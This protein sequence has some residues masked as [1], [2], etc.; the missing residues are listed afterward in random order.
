MMAP[1]ERAVA[2]L[3]ALLCPMPFPAW[4]DVPSWL[5]A[6]S[7]LLAFRV[8][9][10]DRTNLA[11]QQVDSIGW[12]PLLTVDESDPDVLK[13]TWC[14][15]NA[16]ELPIDIDYFEFTPKSYWHIPGKHVEAEWGGKRYT[17]SPYDIRAGLDVEYQFFFSDIHIPPKEVWKSSNIRVGVKPQR[18]KDADRVMLEKTNCVVKICCITDN[19]GRRW[20]VLPGRG[21]RAKRHRWYSH[22][23]KVPHEWESFLRKHKR[24]LRFR[25]RRLLRKKPQAQRADTFHISHQ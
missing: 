10:R 25:L 5:A 7:L 21:Q 8:F 20:R 16:S 15:Q 4:G 19:A 3:T 17:L 23:G 13:V 24:R 2:H 11:R 18:P 1:G 22:T 6:G 12:W 9:T 14:I